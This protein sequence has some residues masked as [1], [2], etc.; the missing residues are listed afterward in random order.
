MNI[1]ML[2]LEERNLH[3]NR[4]LSRDVACHLLARFNFG[5]TV[6]ISD[7]PKIF[8][9]PLRKNWLYLGRKIMRSRTSTLDLAKIDLFSNKFTD[10]QTVP[11]RV[12]N[13]VADEGIIVTDIKNALLCGN[14]ANLYVCSKLT[15]IQEKLILT[16]IAPCGLAIRYTIDENL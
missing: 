3:T 16:H 1:D 12:R 10:M 8:I 11:F 2:C 4:Q 14:I 7:R 5:L 6:V 9:S 15:A 13:Y